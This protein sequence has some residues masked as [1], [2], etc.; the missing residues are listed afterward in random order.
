M[1]DL[2]GEEIDVYNQEFEKIEI[3]DQEIN[4]KSLGNVSFKAS[5]LINTKFENVVFNNV[6]F[7]NTDLSNTTFTNCGLHNCHFI[8]C[9]LI[10][11]SFN[12]STIKNTN[13]TNIIG[14]YLGFSYC[15]ITDVNMKESNLTE[16]R[17]LELTLNRFTVEETNLTK[18]EWNMVSLYGMDLSTCEIENIL[19]DPKYVKGATLSYEQIIHLAP[20]LGIKIK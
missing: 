5:I 12:D 18:T 15:R 2:L 14:K 9:K 20:L 6:K 4:N 3:K 10:G 13:Y 19:I 17:F 8:D 16:A 1:N 7:I 11:T